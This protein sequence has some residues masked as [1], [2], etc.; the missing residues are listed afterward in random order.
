MLFKI[1][2]LFSDVSWP[3]CVLQENAEALRRDAGETR[4]GAHLVRAHRRER[5]HRASVRP[6][7]GTETTLR[8]QI[9]THE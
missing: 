9:I 4:S 8:V 6:R 2:Q 3:C 1:L 5:R 7:R